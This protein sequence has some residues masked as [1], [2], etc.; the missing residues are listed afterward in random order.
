MS[1]IPVTREIDGLRITIRKLRPMRALEIVPEVTAAVAAGFEGLRGIKG[2]SVGDGI[3]VEDLAQLAPAFSNL[4]GAFGD[5]K[6]RKIVPVLLSSIVSVVYPEQTIEGEPKLDKNKQP[7][8]KKA[9]FS[10]GAITEDQVDEIFGNLITLGKVIAFAIEVTF[11]DFFPVAILRAA[12][13]AASEA[14]EDPST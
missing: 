3:T 1:R 14:T 5:G 11:A 8:V 10:N 2:L 6:L 12:K 9:S 7:M 13:S 4:A